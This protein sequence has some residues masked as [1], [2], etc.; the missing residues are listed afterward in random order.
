[1]C[2][3]RAT[4]GGALARG[5]PKE[6]AL[7]LTVLTDDEHRTPAGHAKHQPEGAKVAI[8]EPKLLLADVVEH[9]RHQATLLRMPICAQ[10]D[11]RTHGF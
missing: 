7:S 9:L 1:L 10:K 6:F 11:I 5:T 2:V 3:H 4:A 8:L